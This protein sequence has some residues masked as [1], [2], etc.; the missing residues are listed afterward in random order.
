MCGEG[1]RGMNGGDAGSG[2]ADGCECVDGEGSAGVDDNLAVEVRT[3]TDNLRGGFGDD[4]IGHAEP[5]DAGVEDGVLP[6]DS[7][8]HGWEG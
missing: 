7:W 2:A 6:Q 8:G 3:T 5:E 4:G 1:H